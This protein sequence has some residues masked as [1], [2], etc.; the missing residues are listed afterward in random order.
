MR[1]KRRFHHR[2]VLYKT[3]EESTVT[4]LPNFKK[5]AKLGARYASTYP[6]PVS[7]QRFVM[8]GVKV[9]FVVAS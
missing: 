4:H 6:K 7:Y 3:L 1:S 5:L 8:A 9:V 2:Y